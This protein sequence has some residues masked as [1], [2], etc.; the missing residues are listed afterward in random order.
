M[1]V[2]RARAGASECPL[3]MTPAGPSLLSDGARRACSA[4]GVPA[5]SEG[6]G[7]GD[8]V[9]CFSKPTFFLLPT[10][11]KDGMA[12]EASRVGLVPTGG[13][14]GDSSSVGPSPPF[15]PPL[16]PF[17][18]FLAARAPGLG[19]A[20]FLLLF[21]AER[22]L[23]GAAVGLAA[24]GT[25]AGKSSSWKA[26]LPRGRGGYARWGPEVTARA[27]AEDVEAQRLGKSSS[28]SFTGAGLRELTQGG[29][30]GQRCQPCPPRHAPLY[31]PPSPY[32]GP[33]HTPTVSTHLPSTGP[34]AGLLAGRRFWLTGPFTEA[35]LGPVGHGMPGP[36]Y[37]MASGN[38]GWR[39]AGGGGTHCP[40][41]G[42]GSPGPSP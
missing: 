39:R 1:G 3:T 13:A 15:F 33:H 20:P 26:P 25:K 24:E 38:E 17:P 6:G 8:G 34:A 23:V 29:G 35:S 2:P 7:G 16:P 11:V 36:P 19:L 18:V 12:L 30:T 31:L 40:S 21:Q 32:P 28:L 4:P 10:L 27:E 14:P 22:R 9:P 37:I 41:Q 42:P 5:C